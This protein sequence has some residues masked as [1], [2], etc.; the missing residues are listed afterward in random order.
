M[1]FQNEDEEEDLS[2]NLSSEEFNELTNNKSYNR[3]TIDSQKEKE[4]NINIDYDKKENEKEK[5][6]MPLYNNYNIFFRI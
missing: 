3:F 2:H 4:I 1:S 5:S 6:S